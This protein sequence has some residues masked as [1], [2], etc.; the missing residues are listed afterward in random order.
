MFADDV[1]VFSQ[2]A[3]GLKRAISI[4]TRYFGNINLTVNYDKSQ[5]MIFNKR[6]VLLNRHPDH[7][8]H[9]DG[10][11]LKVVRE[12]TY[13]GFKLVP[14]G[15]ASYGSEELFHKSR[16]SWFAISNL[17]YKHKRLATDKAFQIFDQLVTSIGLYNC[18]SWLPLVMTKN[19]V[20]GEENILAFWDKFKL[21]TL[22]QKIG[23]MVLGVHK[24]SSRLG[25]MGELGRYPLLIKGLC[26][27]LK[28]HAHLNKINNPNSLIGLSVQEM[29]SNF[30]DDKST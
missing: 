5:V 23:R 24:K 21:E 4:T 10:Q 26:H 13:L 9:V 6:G 2:S 17:I 14:S 12:Y 22:N 29:K 7:V 15:T 1:V 16:R 19:S 11:E 27:V 3:S 25:V 30:S 28:Y 8:F 20:T 18:E